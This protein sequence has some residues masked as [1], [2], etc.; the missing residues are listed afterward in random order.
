MFVQERGDTLWLAPFVPTAWLENGKSIE[1]QDAP[2]NFGNV[3]YT[4]ASNIDAGSITATITPPQRQTPKEIVL[5]LRHPEG[6]TLSTVE[7][8]GA[9]VKQ[10]S[11][12]DST[13]HVSPG[14]EAI[15]LTAH[16]AN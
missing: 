8:T 4:I 14:A 13:I 9:T 16:Y 15:T 7:A 2:T 3:A 12:E 11:P 6:K 10:I 1:I 5:R